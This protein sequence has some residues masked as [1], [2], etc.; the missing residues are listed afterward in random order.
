[1]VFGILLAGIIGGAIAQQKAITGGQDPP[2]DAPVDQQEDPFQRV[3]CPEEITIMNNKTDKWIIPMGTMIPQFVVHHTVGLGRS[4]TLNV[5]LPKKEFENFCSWIHYGMFCDIN[6]TKENLNVLNQTV[7]YFTNGVIIDKVAE[8]IHK[9]L[10]STNRTYNEKNTSYAIEFKHNNPN[11]SF[12][13]GT[14]FLSLFSLKTEGFF[15]Y[16]I[17]KTFA[18]FILTHYTYH[19]R[20]NNPDEVNDFYCRAEDKDRIKSFIKQYTNKEFTFFDYF[21]YVYPEIYQLF[22]YRFG[23]MFNMIKERG[24]YTNI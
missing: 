11:R 23:Y 1:M 3:F 13:E 21:E 20:F 7:S 16:D 2:A 19:N 14:I 22:M 6:I 18:H 12:S 17:D 10:S 8:K 4:N 24:F 5:S 9:C 15:W